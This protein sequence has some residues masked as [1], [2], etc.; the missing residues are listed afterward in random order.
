MVKVIGINDRGIYGRED[1]Q[2]N[3]IVKK[4]VLVNL[5]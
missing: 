2:I 4:R 3:K 1:R 5:G